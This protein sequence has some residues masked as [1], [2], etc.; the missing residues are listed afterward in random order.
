MLFTNSYIE[1]EYDNKRN[2]EVPY[3]QAQNVF[4]YLLK[5]TPN[6]ARVCVERSIFE[7]IKFDPAIRELKTLMRGYILLNL[8]K[9]SI[10]LNIQ[11]CILFTPN[12]T[13]KEIQND[14]KKNCSFLHICFKKKQ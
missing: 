3:F 1:D 5:Y 9:L 10:S 6:P 4:A 11:M 2:K 13:Q 8:I 7:T 14:M 12:H